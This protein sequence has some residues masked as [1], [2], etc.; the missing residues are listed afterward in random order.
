MT[1]NEFRQRVYLALQA[2]WDVGPLS[3]YSFDGEKYEPPTPTDGDLQSGEAWVRLIVRHGGSSI[4]SFGPVGRRKFEN[5]ATVLLMIFT[6]P[7]TGTLVQDNLNQAFVN[8]FSRDLGRKDVFGGE[9]NY[10]E[11]GTAE[12]WQM[13]ES[14]A[15]FTYDETR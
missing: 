10:R 5:Q 4:K 7:N 11:R 8:T 12:G 1:P 2:T 13:A 15:D 9:T 3:P 6:V 14:T